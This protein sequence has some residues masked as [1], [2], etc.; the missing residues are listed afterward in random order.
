MFRGG[1]HASCQDRSSTRFDFSYSA[2]K[3]ARDGHR[4]TTSKVVR[5]VTNPMHVDVGYTSFHIGGR[6]RDRKTSWL[7]VALLAAVLLALGVLV[8][9]SK[10]TA[11]PGDVGVE[12]I[13]H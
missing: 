3:V 11:A 9:P 1:V 10:A 5:L 12:G 2:G 4:Q 8:V 6:G 13:S 7:G